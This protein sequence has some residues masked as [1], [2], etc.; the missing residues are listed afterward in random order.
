M[1]ILKYIVESYLILV[2]VLF[3]IGFAIKHT[4]LIPDKLI[5]LILLIVG[6]VLGIVLALQ[7]G[8]TVF[9]GLIQGLLCAGGAVIV[10]QVPKQL[11]K[12]E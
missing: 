10:H 12:D 2:P 1:D 7:V 3:V 8:D 9:T 11:R 4:E 6:A 5:P